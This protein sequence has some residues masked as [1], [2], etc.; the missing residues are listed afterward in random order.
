MAQERNSPPSDSGSRSYPQE[1]IDAVV[2]ELADSNKALI[3][4]SL[5]GATFTTPTRRHLFRSMVLVAGHTQSTAELLAAS[6]RIA[7]FFR[8]LLLDFEDST[9][10]EREQMIFIL[11]RLEHIQDFVLV[12]YDPRRGLDRVIVNILSNSSFNHLHFIVCEATPSFLTFALSAARVITMD[13]FS[14]IREDVWDGPSYA[15]QSRS[16]APLRCLNLPPNHGDAASVH[17]LLLHSTTSLYLSSL[18]DLLLHENHGPEFCAALL[19]AVAPSLERLR[20][21]CSPQAADTFRVLFDLPALLPAL[22]FLQFQIRGRN[23]TRTAEFVRKLRLLAPL[24]EIQ[25]I[26]TVHHPTF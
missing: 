22:R 26:S 25:I 15:P 23:D 4:C 13:D 14:V 21:Q 20:I 7:P 16:P 1:I 12:S 6:P 3:S 10:E 18:K 11:D 9:D 8:V 2:D 24:V 17:E 5:A 19:A